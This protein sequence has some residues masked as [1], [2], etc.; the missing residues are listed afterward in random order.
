MAMTVP[1]RGAEGG[2][3]MLEI[4]V[5]SPGGARAA[6]AGGADRLELCAALELGGLTPSAGLVAAVL[7]VARAAGVP[8]HAMVRPRGGDFAYDADDLACAIAEARALT[9]QGVDGLVFGACRDAELDRAALECWLAAIDAPRALTFHRAVDLLADPVAAVPVIAA[10]G[11]GYILTSGGA[12]AAA[13]GL[14][15]IGAMA[16]AAGPGCAIIAG[17][18]VRADNAAAILTATGVRQLHASAS[19]AGAAPDGKVAAL[20]FGAGPRRTT[21]PAAVAALKLVLD[22][23]SN[24]EQSR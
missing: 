10:L 7:P 14:A 13:D 22:N 9:A 24:L 2:R 17:A 5:D 18:G 6:I 4:C 20:G 1:R 21:D 12:P 8:V 11:F 23:Q 19:R 15:T 16:A 3:A